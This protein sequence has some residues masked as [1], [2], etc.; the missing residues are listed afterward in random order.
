M[1]YLLLIMTIWGVGLVSAVFPEISDK[2]YN[3]SK[4]SIF[5][6]SLLTLFGLIISGLIIA[7]LVYYL[8]NLSGQSGTISFILNLSLVLV[9]LTLIYKTIIVQFPSANSKKD[10]FISLIVNLILYIPCIFNGL[11]DSTMKNVNI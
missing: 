4:V 2:S 5:K 3:I 8:K 6:K 11:F 9:I 10:S 7:W 1:R